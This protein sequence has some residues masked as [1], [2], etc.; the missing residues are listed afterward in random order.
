MTE[1]IL[2]IF[3]VRHEEGIKQAKKDADVFNYSIP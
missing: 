3:L 2:C 1:N